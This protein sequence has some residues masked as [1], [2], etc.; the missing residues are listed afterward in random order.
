[1][2]S[3]VKICLWP[4]TLVSWPPN[5]LWPA[6]GRHPRRRK[7]MG[8]G[9][10]EVKT[11]LSNLRAVRV[12][13][14][15]VC[16]S[17]WATLCFSSKPSNFSDLEQRDILLSFTWGCLL[18]VVTQRPRLLDP[19]RQPASSVAVRTTWLPAMTL[20]CSVNLGHSAPEAPGLHGCVT[21]TV[22]QGLVHRG[23]CAWLPALLSLP[24]NY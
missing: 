24:W 5:R 4:N 23:L 12:F 1:M 22:T 19:P 13:W 15:F 17:A 10:S 11:Q 3:C 14:A 8:C 16:R 2:T 6:V 20:S 21:C 18:I 9:R 7:T